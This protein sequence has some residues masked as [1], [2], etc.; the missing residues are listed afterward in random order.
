MPPNTQSC[1][2]SADDPNALLV[3]GIFT[4]DAPASTHPLAAV[5]VTGNTSTPFVVPSGAYRYEFNIASSN[6][7]TLTLYVHGVATACAPAS[8]DPKDPALGNLA[9]ID[10]ITTFTIA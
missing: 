1:W 5:T 4:Q 9:S 6:K 3:G 7:F 2:F 8:F 10:R